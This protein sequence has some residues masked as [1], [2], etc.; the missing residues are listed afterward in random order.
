[1]ANLAKMVKPCLYEKENNSGAWWHM[2]V[3]PATQEA[4]A[5][6]LL[7]PGRLWLQC[8]EIT[9]LHSSLGDSETLSQK[10]KINKKLFIYIYICIYFFNCT[11]G[12]GVHVQIMQDC[13]IGIYMAMRFA[14]S[15]PQ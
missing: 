15:I 10:I 14:A 11:L 4:E 3:V 12:S 1:M 2:P 9:P 13:Y 7:E 8:A 6:E 5:G